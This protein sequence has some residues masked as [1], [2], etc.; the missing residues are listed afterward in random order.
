MH[1]T[2]GALLLLVPFAPGSP[3]AAQP[4]DCDTDAR[5]GDTI[6]MALDVAGRRG[7]PKGITGQVY[8]AVPVTP[9]MACRGSRAPE[10]VLH[11]Q[12]GDALRGPPA[13]D[14]L[15][16]TIPP[17]RTPHVSVEQ[18]PGQP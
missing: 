9:G 2:I 3:A 13:I 5:P 15:R 10:D 4:A 1:P 18:L 6:Q 11:G 8:V 7:V 12:P 16:G 17:P 14:L